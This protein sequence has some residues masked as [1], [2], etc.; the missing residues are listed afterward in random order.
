MNYSNIYS[1]GRPRKK[2]VERPPRILPLVAGKLPRNVILP[3]GVIVTR[4]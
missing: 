4:M 3:V 1:H 2:Q